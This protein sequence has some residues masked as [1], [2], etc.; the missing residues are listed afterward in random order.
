MTPDFFIDTTFSHL[1][2]CKCGLRFKE[3]QREQ[4]ELQSWRQRLLLSCD[5]G[6][7]K[8]AYQNRETRLWS[9]KEPAHA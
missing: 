2:K 6:A 3:L 9:F 1:P 4:S 5:C 8:Y 7:A